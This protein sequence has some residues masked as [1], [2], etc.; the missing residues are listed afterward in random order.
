MSN[1]LTT[2]I[3]KH[4]LRRMACKMEACCGE[5]NTVDNQIGDGDIGVTAVTGFRAV[6]ENLSELPDDLGMALA[7]CGQ[8]FVRDRGS[9]FGTLFAT[10]V[11]AAAKE[12]KGETCVS[13]TQVP[14]LLE[15]SV[16]QMAQRGRSSLGDKT[17]LDSLWAIKVAIEEMDDPGQM[18]A[19]ASIAAAKVLEDFKGLPCKLGRARI[20]GE[21]TI[22]LDDP[23]MIVI[24]RLVD[25][26]KGNEQS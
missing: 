1:V 13:W 17:V 6:L 26:L 20:F 5:L 22:G 18:L 21:K 24:C 7:K 16:E 14:S 8:D 11:L 9:S 4:G 19:A 3:L 10:G 23:G 2:N 12:I 25:S 15:R